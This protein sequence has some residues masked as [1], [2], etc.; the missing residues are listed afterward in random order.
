MFGCRY[1]LVHSCW[2]ST[3][4]HYFSRKHPSHA[5]FHLVLLLYGRICLCWR[6]VSGEIYRCTTTSTI[7]SVHKIAIPLGNSNGDIVH[8]YLPYWRRKF[9]CIIEFRH[10]C[11]QCISHLFPL[12]SSDTTMWIYGICVGRYI[13]RRH[14]HPCHALLDGNRHDNILYTLLYL[15]TTPRQSRPLDCIPLLPRHTRISAKYHLP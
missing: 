12:G 9:S 5:T 15:N 10:A 14:S 11:Y 13:H 6:G 1:T 4:Q 2:S 8:P 7:K 3:K